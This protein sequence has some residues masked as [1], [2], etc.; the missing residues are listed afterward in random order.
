MTLMH[1][2]NTWQKNINKVK[3]QMINKEMYLTNKQLM[4]TIYK[5]LEN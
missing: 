1:V 5:T 2:Q 3:G 4:S